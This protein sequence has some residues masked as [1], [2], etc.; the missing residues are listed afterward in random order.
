MPRFKQSPND[1]SQ[2]MLFSTSVDDAIPAD[3]AVR[4]I[5]ELMDM[6]DWSGL[7]GS[8]S[9]TGCPPYHPQ[10]MTKVLAYAY[11]LGI[12]SSRRIAD[13]V[14]NDKRF[15]WL[16]GGLQPDFRT[17]ARFR[18]DKGAY[19]VTLFEDSARLADE[20]GLV[21]LNVA[22]TD[23]SKI[24]SAASR[25]AVYDQ[26]RIDKEKTRIE[27]I[28]REA[29]EVDQAEDAE[30]GE[31]TGKELP[32]ELKDA[33]LRKVRL[34][35]AA[36]QLKESNRPRVVTSDPDSRVMKTKDGNRPCYN[37]QSTVDAENQIIV[38]MDV[39]SNEIDH[40]LLMPMIEKTQQILGR[41][42][43]LDEADTGY[44]DEA[45]LLALEAAGKEALMPPQTGPKEKREELFHSECFLHDESEDVLVC[46]AG[47]K[48]AF[49]RLHKTGSGTYRDYSVTGC[50]SCSFYVQCA[51]GKNC[52]IVSRSIV[53]DMREKMRSR[54]KTD[55]GKKLYALRSQTVEPVFGQIKRN[56]GF[57]RLLL[58]GLNGA[59][60][61]LALMCLMH[62]MKKCA[63]KLEKD[64]RAAL[65]KARE[66]SLGL[67]FSGARILMTHYL[68][69]R[70]YTGRP[71]A[72]TIVYSFAFG[73][74]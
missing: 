66:A 51:G 20:A 11:S 14:E 30:Y 43:D 16:A 21:F 28:L 29:E 74:A 6:L 32:A 60:A 10:V 2:V 68:G 59:K 64:A 19:L 3:S 5:S 39:V 69:C 37:L 73:T 41:S 22:C 7:V 48:L 27:D 45:T 57:D 70:A 34:E 42:A 71:K 67:L 26:S 33:K 49:R 12:R 47:R 1:P 61:E 44:C 54:L 24:R 58:R 72:K 40:A 65:K 36:Q 18:R 15:I 38:A 53:Y 35:K 13:L 55:E 52:R 31:G 8:Y 62:N 56:M 9:N 63:R 46:P 23:G 25:K 50:K 4:V 17:L